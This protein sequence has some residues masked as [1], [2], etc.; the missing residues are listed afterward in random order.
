MRPPLS[1][2]H[3]A[4]QVHE[5]AC[6]WRWR[7]QL[8]ADRIAELERLELATERVLRREATNA[9]CASATVSAS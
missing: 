5:E 2:A 4:G 6:S 3:Q 7:S 8:I 9:T 1:P